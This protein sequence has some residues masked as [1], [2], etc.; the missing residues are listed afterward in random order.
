MKIKKLLVTSACVFAIFLSGCEAVNESLSAVNESLANMNS[1]LGGTSTN[2][3]TTS[4][5]STSVQ[6]PQSVTQATTTAFTNS[7]KSDVQAL[8]NSAKPTIVE[9][10]GKIACNASGRVMGRYTAP[11]SFTNFY[12]SPFI[13]MPY[14]T[15][16]CVTPIR[17]H[18][19]DKVAANALRFTVDY[20]SPQSEE[21]VRRTYTAVRQPDGEWLFKW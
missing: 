20:M 12:V 10:I 14:H 7:E 18:G 13:N 8:I 16:G 1:A 5:S 19:W 3:T 4:S 9:V 2:D 21:T 15:S 11:D 17:I 6:V